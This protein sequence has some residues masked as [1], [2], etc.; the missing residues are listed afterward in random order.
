MTITRTRVGDAPLMAGMA[1]RLG[2]DPEIAAS[3]GSISG[4]ELAEMKV[5]CGQC[6]KHDACTIWLLEHQDHQAET[7]DYCLNIQELQYIRAVQTR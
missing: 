5:R 7:P 2:V 4:D 1:A 3:D 6:S